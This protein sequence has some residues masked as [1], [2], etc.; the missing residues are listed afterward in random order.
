[1]SKKLIVLGGGAAGWLTALYL[2]KV[3][4]QHNIKLIESK[5]I[6][7]LGA[8]EG[9]T[10]HLINFLNYLEIDIKELLKETKGTIKNGINF[11]NWNGDNKKYF[12]GFESLNFLNNFQVEELFTQDN[13]V[14]YLKN[15]I[16][17]NLDLD[18][19]LKGII[20]VKPLTSIPSANIS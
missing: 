12:H 14:S 7:I 11:E 13:Y 18:N 17:K 6:G 9:S 2:K 1:M 20:P 10:P 4:K 15:C 3:F 5:K 19:V 16:S 8:G